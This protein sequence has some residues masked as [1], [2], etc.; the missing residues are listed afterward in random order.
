[1]PD[2]SCKLGHSTRLCGPPCTYLHSLRRAALVS[3]NAQ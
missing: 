1:M 2:R 3:S